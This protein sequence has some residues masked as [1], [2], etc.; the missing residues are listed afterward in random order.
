MPE[1]KS[2][3]LERPPREEEAPVE[4]EA[5]A[6]A[7]PEAEAS[8]EAEPPVEAAPPVEAEAVPEE[9]LALPPLVWA[10]MNSAPSLVM[11]L[12]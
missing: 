9:L 11:P 5:E 7:S 3:Q 2:F 1:N 6:S 10:T 12:L 4:P 8:V